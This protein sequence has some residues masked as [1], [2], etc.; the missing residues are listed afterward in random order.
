MLHNMSNPLYAVWQRMRQRCTNKNHFAYAR[1]GG[2][3]IKICKR[4]D[5]LENFVAD[6]PGWC[7]RM[8]LDRIDNDGDYKPRNCRWAT[9]TQSNRNK[10]NCL[11]EAKVRHIRKMLGNRSPGNRPLDNRTR[12]YKIAAKF[13]VSQSAISKILLNQRWASVQ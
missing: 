4:W 10:S 1:Y 11:T 8:M 13:G 7:P 2:R 9:Y 6:M 5:K 3:G 12:Q